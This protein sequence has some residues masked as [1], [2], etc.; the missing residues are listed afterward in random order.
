MPLKSFLLGG[1]IAGSEQGVANEEEN[2]PP[3]Q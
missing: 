2:T 1:D 3:D